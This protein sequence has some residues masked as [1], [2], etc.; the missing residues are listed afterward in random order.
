V[1]AAVVVNQSL[2]LAA[3]AVATDQPQ[4][5]LATELPTLAAV[6]AAHVLTALPATAGTVDQESF[7]SDGRCD[8]ANFAEVENNQVQ[9]VIVIANS[10]INDL[11][12]PES[13]PVGQAFIASLGIP[14]TW[15]Q[16][17]YTANF[18]GCYAGID[19]TYNPTTD[20]FE[21]PTISES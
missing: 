14:G 5:T 7:I 12:F 18:R 21:P 15:L 9:R 1:A 2:A 20:T 11:P 13:E 8:M 4:E 3:A 10:D 19:Y 17:S 6:V 16:T